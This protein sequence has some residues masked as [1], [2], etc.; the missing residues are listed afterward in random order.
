M[1]KENYTSLISQLSDRELVKN[2]YATQGILFVLSLLL[3]FMIFRENKLFYDLFY[4]DSRDFFIGIVAGFIIICMD[5]FFMVKLP[6]QYHDDGGVNARVFRNRHPLHI[7]FIAFIVAFVE[8]L[9]FRGII[10]T[11]LGLWISCLIFAFMHYRYLF[12]LFL[13]FNVV[14]V[15]IVIGLL[16]EWT[17]NLWVTIIM[18]F[19]IDFI[20]GCILR[21][22]LFEKREK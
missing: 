19:L 6:M 16:F 15:S 22:K 8:E 5:I 9:L 14:F 1:N 3:Q 7:A 18:H 11:N 17:Q 4:Y 21:F 13:F 12:N 2:L 20:L 10:Q